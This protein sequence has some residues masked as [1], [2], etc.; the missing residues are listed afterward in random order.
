MH[1][2]TELPE[3]IAGF[4]QGSTYSINLWLPCV[5]NEGKFNLGIHME[6]LG[7]T[8]VYTKYILSEKFFTA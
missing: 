2:M 7:K 8:T 5:C 6:E 1:L 4:P 3:R